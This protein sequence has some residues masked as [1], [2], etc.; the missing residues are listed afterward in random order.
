MISENATRVAFLS[1][2]LTWDVCPASVSLLDISERRHL[3]ASR[4]DFPH[5]ISQ[6]RGIVA[7]EGERE[8]GG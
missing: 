6:L 7:E 5:E 2:S 3:K 4:R 1:F 8:R